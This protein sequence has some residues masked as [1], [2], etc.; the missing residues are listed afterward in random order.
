MPTY[1]YSCKE[2]KTIWEEA[3]PIS[4]CLIPTKNKCPHC[5]AKKGNIYRYHGVAPAMKMD[6]NYKIDAPHNEGGFQDAIKRM[7][8]SP[9]VKGTKY[10]D[11]LSAKHL[12]S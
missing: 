7:V 8:N 9:G 1:G 11:K 4:G 6:S 12:S 3:R 10:A 2:C 5:D